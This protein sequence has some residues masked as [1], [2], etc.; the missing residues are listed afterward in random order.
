[1][2]LVHLTDPHLTT[3]PAWRT[4]A[5]R[6]HFGKR[7]LGYLSWARK[8]RWQLRPEWLADLCG[9]VEERHP[10][11]WLISGDLA[12]IGTEEEIRAAG[13][14]LRT[15]APAE[16]VTFVPGNHDVYA[17]E[18][19]RCIRREWGPYLPDDGVY[20]LL[21]R[22][23][24]VAIFGLSTAV[25]TAPLSATGVL[26]DDQLLRLE[27]A[28]ARHR[29]AFR[30]V[31]LHHPPLPHMIRFRKRLRDASA[32]AALLEREPVQLLLHGHRHENQRHER[33][34]A[35]VYCTAPASSETASFR[36][37][38]IERKPGGWSVSASLVERREARF[39]ATETEGWEVSAP[40]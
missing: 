5:G 8:R 9:A 14:W 23:S 38:D 27:T 4:L 22:I 2:R 26:G 28:L 21:Q 10:D 33:L 1:M 25:P 31:L 35:H 6:S 24:D 39:E 3:P 30:V 13:N 37:F 34:G 11:R 7:Y 15:V 12:Q 40:G 18:S 29:D 17:A 16:M 32:L 36:T 20:P 19:W